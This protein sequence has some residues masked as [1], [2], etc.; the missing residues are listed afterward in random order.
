MARY[1]QQMIF[2]TIA[3]MF[4]T[5]LILAALLTN[6]SDVASSVF[7]RKTGE[8]FDLTGQVRISDNDNDPILNVID[9]TGG[10]IGRAHV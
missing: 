4:S 10:K 5:C 1:F 7:A 8:R 9:Q 2:D 3:A 6:C